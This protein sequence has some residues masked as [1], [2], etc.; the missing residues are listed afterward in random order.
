MVVVAGEPDVPAKVELFVTAGE[1]ARAHRR[2]LELTGAGHSITE[3]EVLKNVRERDAR[4]AS[5]E[6]APMV[7]AAD[8]TVLD[9]S[10]MEVE[11]AV[12]AAVA[13]VRTVWEAGS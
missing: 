7:A 11:A 8:A 13:L 9:T 2:W 12:A 6:A 5:R 4:D 3:A 10:T 1:E